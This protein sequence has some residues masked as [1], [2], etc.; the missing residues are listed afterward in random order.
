MVQQE[1]PKDKR[2]AADVLGGEDGE[3][4]SLGSSCSGVSRHARLAWQLACAPAPNTCAALPCPALCAVAAAAADAY[5][6]CYPSYY[7][8]GTVLE[9]S[10][11]EG[12]RPEAVEVRRRACAH[13]LFLRGAA[14]EKCLPDGQ[15]LPCTWPLQSASRACPHLI[16]LSLPLPCF[17]PGWSLQQPMTRRDFASDADWEEYQASGMPSRQ[18]EGRAKMV[19][20]VVLI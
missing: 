3:Q 10:D 5:A 7:D 20:C 6:E 15:C 17:L 11:E 12:A 13:A 9:D 18:A 8:H 16:D 14:A 2:R 4:L 19:S 1:K